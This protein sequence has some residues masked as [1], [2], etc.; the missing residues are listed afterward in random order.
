MP[1]GDAQK[2]RMGGNR[3]D[4]NRTG[5]QLPQR[6]EGGRPDFNRTSEQ[7]PQRPEFD[8]PD[9]DA[10]IAPMPHRAP[11]CDGPGVSRVRA[12]AAVGVSAG[13]TGA[14]TVFFLFNRGMAVAL[15]CALALE[16]IGLAH[17]FIGAQA[18]GAPSADPSGAD[19]RDAAAP[20]LPAAVCVALV[21]V[22][23]FCRCVGRIMGRPSA[24]P[25]VSFD[26]TTP[27]VIG[28]SS[29]AALDAADGTAC[30]ADENAAPKIV[31][32]VPIV[33]ASN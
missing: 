15:S 26:G 7:L 8:R 10:E 13:V 2:P 18:C 28:D 27:V 4:F 32:G 17:I 5:E 33:A 11:A 29:R 20:N 22:A 14:A 1:A 25:E 23:S 30:V 9:F 21:L 31:F 12:L 24:V 3:P 16:A 19:C 6:P